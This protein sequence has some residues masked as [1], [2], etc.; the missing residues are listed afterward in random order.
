MHLDCV[1]VDQKENSGERGHD[2][3]VQK[4][5]RKFFRHDDCRHYLH[6]IGAFSSILSARI[7]QAALQFT[8]KSQ[9]AGLSEFQSDLSLV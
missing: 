7:G 8:E 5:C 4:V 3:R 2:H 9:Q 6:R 1:L